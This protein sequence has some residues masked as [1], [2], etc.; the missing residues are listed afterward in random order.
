MGFA[1]LYRHWGSV[2]AVGPIGGV[3]VQV[4]VKVECTVVQ[5][6]RLCT[7]RTAHRRIRGIALLFLDH[8]TRRGWGVCVTPR[9]LF[10]SGNDLVPIVN[11]GVWTP[12]PVWTGVDPRAGLDR[13]GP[14]GRSGQVWTPGPVWTGVENL[15]PT[16]IRSPVPPARSQSLYRLSYPANLP[17]GTGCYFHRTKTIG[18]WN[19]WLLRWRLN[20]NTG[21]FKMIDRARV[22]PGTEGTNQNRHWN[23]HRWH[24]TNSLERTRLLCWCLW[25]HKGYTYRAPVRY[26]TKTGSVVLLNKKTH[27]RNDCRSFNNLSHTIHLR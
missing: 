18:A 3:E 23:H 2:Q 17:V 13:R 22:Y 6:L 4:Y 16:W 19:R 5:A 20:G 15:A 7:G 11:K 10:T 9:P 25:N 12:R 8:C 14:Q 26:V 24:A 27:I 1:P 21:L